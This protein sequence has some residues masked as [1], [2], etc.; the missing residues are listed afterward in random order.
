M[1]RRSSGKEET[2]EKRPLSG[3]RRA[4]GFPQA[5]VANQ[6]AG[7]A[8]VATTRSTKAWLEPSQIPTA[9]LPS[10]PSTSGHRA[11][12]RRVI[13]H[14]GAASTVSY[15]GLFAIKLRW[16]QAASCSLRPVSQ[17]FA[18][19]HSARRKKGRAAPNAL[20]LLLLFLLPG[21]ELRPH[22]AA[23][24]TR[25]VTL[26]MGIIPGLMLP[27]GLRAFCT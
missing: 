27:P 20:L 25:R 15:F 11:C 19:S 1:Q 17:R 16:E 14:P 2:Q 23:R 5:A 22:G 13:K 26:S 7:H 18:A 3:K 12:S 4:D 8:P 10:T 21:A 9:S 24:L 6:R